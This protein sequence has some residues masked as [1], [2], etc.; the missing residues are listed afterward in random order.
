VS[1][2]GACRDKVAFSLP[3]HRL[4]S[5]NFKRLPFRSTVLELVK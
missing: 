2:S 1:I 5:A 3:D 4:S